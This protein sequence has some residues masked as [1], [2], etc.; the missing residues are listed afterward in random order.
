ML[1][2]SKRLARTRTFVSWMGLLTLFWYWIHQKICSCYHIV[3]EINFYPPRT[4]E[5]VH[6]DPVLCLAFIPNLQTTCSLAK[7]SSTFF[8]PK[9][10]HDSQRS[11]HEMQGLH[12]DKWCA[13]LVILAAGW[14]V[15]NAIVP[16]GS[17][18]NVWPSS[19]PYLWLFINCL[20]FF[21]FDW[22]CFIKH[23]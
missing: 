3:G 23:W 10:F 13:C 1:H 2:A 8:L 22:K 19:G 7:F 14:S 11:L 16:A 20:D 21:F 15:A 4:R 17:K 12:C 6:G 5:P 9:F 18:G